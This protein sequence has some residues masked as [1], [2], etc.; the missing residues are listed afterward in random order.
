MSRGK[1]VSGLCS[2]K[3]DT[4]SGV[5]GMWQGCWS[6]LGPSFSR[7]R[8]SRAVPAPRGRKQGEPRVAADR[9]PYQGRGDSSPSDR[10]GE[11]TGR[12]WEGSQPRWGREQEGGLSE[13]EAWTISPSWGGPAIDSGLRGTWAILVPSEREFNNRAGA[14]FVGPSFKK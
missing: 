5:P 7:K 8:V 12:C 9:A 2:S 1:E 3:P 13:M 11:V 14:C 10:D 6:V 4:A